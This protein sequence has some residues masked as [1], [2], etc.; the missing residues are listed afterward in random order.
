[1]SINVPFANL[2]RSDLSIDRTY[3]GG[4]Q[5]HSG[6]DPLQR[7]LGVGN[8]G[9]FRFVG[10]VQKQSVRLAVLYTSGEHPDWPDRI[11]PTTGTVTYF[12]DNR[13]PG[14]DL[15]D[16][17]RKGN[18]L[19]RQL[20]AMASG[21]KSD[22][23]AVPPILVFSKGGRGRDVVFRG[24]AVPG[25]PTMAPGDDLVAVWRSRASGGSRTIVRRSPFWMRHLLAELGLM[26]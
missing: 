4:P 22:R 18:Q 8:M 6:A 12:G 9:G 17:P 1:M 10:S 13:S 23:L 24:L 11:D 2:T 26:R 21:T 16:T 14:R 5:A 15:H 25:A 20:F 7:L 3:E 19:L